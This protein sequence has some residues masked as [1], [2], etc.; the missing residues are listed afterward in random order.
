MVL[1]RVI[2]I[3]E[4]DFAAANYGQPLCLLKVKLLMVPATNNRLYM[5]DSDIPGHLE[6]RLPNLR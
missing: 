6:G 5:A 3:T 2:A 4:K 1:V